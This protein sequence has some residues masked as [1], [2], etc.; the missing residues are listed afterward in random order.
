MRHLTYEFEV[1]N[2]INR[3]IKRVRSYKGEEYILF[4]D[5]CEKKV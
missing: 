4:N 3:M 5:Y 1:E 2:Q